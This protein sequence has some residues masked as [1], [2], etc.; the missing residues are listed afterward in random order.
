MN[1]FYLLF[2]ILSFFFINDTYSQS[3]DTLFIKFDK[4]YMEQKIN[5][6][7]NSKY[8]IFK[9]SGNNGQFYFTVKQK[10]SK[11]KEISKSL[12]NNNLK[13]NKTLYP[14]LL[15]EKSLD[16]WKLWEHFENKIIFL[17]KKNCLFR[18]KFQ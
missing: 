17:L 1:R 3:L 13:T 16:D 11:N 9:N 7:D 2:F 4:K 15:N 8:Y 10:V 18:K 14:S 5:L 12:E 6:T